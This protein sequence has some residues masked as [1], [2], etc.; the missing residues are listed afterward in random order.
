[1]YKWNSLLTDLL[2]TFSRQVPF[3]TA[4]D[5]MSMMKAASATDVQKQEQQKD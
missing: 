5:A 3:V 4:V 1:M 2:H